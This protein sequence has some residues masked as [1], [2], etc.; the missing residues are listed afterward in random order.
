LSN[1]PAELVSILMPLMAPG[2]L[3]KALLLSLL[4]EARWPRPAALWL[5]AAVLV[6]V[7]IWCCSDCHLLASG[8]FVWPCAE[9]PP[10]KG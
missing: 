2:A 4:S 3:V 6:A 7:V 10:H 1:L 9:V 8:G 5:F